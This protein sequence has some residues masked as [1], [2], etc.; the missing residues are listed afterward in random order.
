MVNLEYFVGF[1]EIMY[2][3]TCYSCNFIKFP[4]SYKYKIMPADKR[5][6]KIHF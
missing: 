2:A 1:T 5:L 6:Q 4:L 3:N